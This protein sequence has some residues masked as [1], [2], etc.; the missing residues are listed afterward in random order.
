V[1]LEY[2]W[3]LEEGLKELLKEPRRETSTSAGGKS[4]RE[5]SACAGRRSLVKFGST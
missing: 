2:G 3:R 5:I 1:R 4:N